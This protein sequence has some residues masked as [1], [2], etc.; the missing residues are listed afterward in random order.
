MPDGT[1]GGGSGPWM[2]RI[3]HMSPAKC[4]CATGCEDVLRFF[5]A[6]TVEV[7]L[8]LSRPKCCQEPGFTASGRLLGWSEPDGYHFIDLGPKL[9]A[10]PKDPASDRRSPP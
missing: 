9:E 4:V 6:A 10:G 8:S 5:D 3:R 2:V 1:G 7:V